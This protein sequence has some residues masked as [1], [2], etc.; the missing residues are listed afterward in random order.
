VARGP[1]VVRGGLQPLSEENALEKMYQAVDEWKTHTDTCVCELKLL[2]LVDFQQ[3]VGE[4]LV[5]ASCPTIIILEYSL[6][7]RIA[8]NVVAVTL[9]TGIMFSC[10]LSY[11]FVYGCFTKNYLTWTP[12]NT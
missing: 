7:L 2:L 12:E 3:K 4:F 8:K 6:N 10:S 9:T 5:S 11:T 1:A